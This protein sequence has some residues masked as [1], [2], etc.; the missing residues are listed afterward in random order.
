MWQRSS[1]VEQGNHN[2]LVGGSNPSAATNDIQSRRRLQA[3]LIETK[4]A[5]GKVRH[6]HI[7]SLGSVDVPPS[8]RGRLTFWAKLHERFAKL[9]NR[10]DAEAQAKILGPIH[11]RIPM[12]TPD[13]Q[14]SLQVENAKADEELWSHLH[15][16]DAK[17]IEGHKGLIRSAEQTVASTQAA[18]IVADAKI[19][20]AKERI[21]RIQRGENVAGGFGEPMDFDKVLRAAG[22]TASDLK[23]ARL[24]AVITE[25][26]GE[27]AF[28]ALMQETHRRHKLGERAAIRAIAR[29]LKLA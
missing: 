28:K 12:V 15:E 13:E 9:D 1:A 11:A 4:R 7:A 18:M 6:E 19:A 2:P 21:A 14:R 24:L 25:V 27:A 26:G 5:G 23:R 17:Q 8:V 20:A 3:S 16:S 10:V 22:W 29:R